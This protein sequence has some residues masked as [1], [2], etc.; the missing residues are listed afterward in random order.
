VASINTGQ[1]YA[2]LTAEVKCICMSKRWWRAKQVSNTDGNY[3]TM[4][5]PCKHGSR[6]CMPVHAAGTCTPLECW[7]YQ[8]V[9]TLSTFAACNALYG[10]S[11]QQEC[12][13]QCSGMLIYKGEC[14]PGKTRN[15][16]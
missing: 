11:A 16:G 2:T 3:V 9:Q 6:N 1:T 12:A 7:G 4:N 15:E 8:F 5:R 13:V 14:E 10:C